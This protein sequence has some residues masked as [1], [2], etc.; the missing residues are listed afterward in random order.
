MYKTTFLTF[1][2]HHEK[3]W[4]DECDHDKPSYYR[5][6]V[7]DIFSVFYSI[8]QARAFFDYLNSNH[9]N[10]KFTMET[11]CNGKLP[12]LDVYIDNS[13][14]NFLTKQFIPLFNRKLC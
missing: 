1:M 9:E 11:E 14:R 6:Y 4:L 12:F 10:I 8:D 2:G 3:I 7:D 13:G 5:R